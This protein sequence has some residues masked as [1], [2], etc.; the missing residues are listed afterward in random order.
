MK[1]SIQELAEIFPEAKEVIREKIIETFDSLSNARERILS[2]YNRS[3]KDPDAAPVCEAVI[4]IISKNE[5]IPLQRRLKR[6]SWQ[7]I[8][9]TQPEKIK[10]NTVNVEELKERLNLKYIVETYGVKLRKQN[11]KNSMGLCPFHKESTP[12]FSVSEKLF[13][14]FGC[15]KKGDTIDFIKEIEGVEFKE[16]IKILQR[17]E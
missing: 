12:S 9:L 11:S 10:N 3:K 8:I 6:L 15:G 16:A 7:H 5:I 2:S 1:Y 13:Y 4:E 14:C 17:Y